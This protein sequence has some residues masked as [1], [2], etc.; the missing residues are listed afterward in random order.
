MP[1][2]ASHI[3]KYKKRLKLFHTDNINIVLLGTTDHVLINKRENKMSYSDLKRPMF[4]SIETQVKKFVDFVFGTL[5][6]QFSLI[7]NLGIEGKNI[8]QY[9]QLLKQRVKQKIVAAAN[10][11]KQEHTNQNDAIEETLFFYRLIEGFRE[12]AQKIHSDNTKVTTQVI[13]KK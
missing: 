4:D 13:N 12:L 11:K 10:L 6:S 9:Q 7:H 5:N 3:I 1:K 2:T 8:A